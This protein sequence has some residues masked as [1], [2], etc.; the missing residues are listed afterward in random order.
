MSATFN[1]VPTGP[2][3]FREPHG[4]YSSARSETSTVS[5]STVRTGVQ[6]ML[7]VRRRGGGA[8]DGGDNE[9][10]PVRGGGG[11]G[12][13]PYAKQRA[14]KLKSKQLRRQLLELLRA[15]GTAA[16]LC[17]ALRLPPPT[18]HNLEEWIRA[19]VLSPS[20]LNATQQLTDRIARAVQQH[21]DAKELRVAGSTARLTVN[22]DKIDVDLAFYCPNA[23]AIKSLQQLLGKELAADVAWHRQQP[24]NHVR[25]SDGALSHR[26]FAHIVHKSCPHLPA[27]VALFTNKA[28]F[29]AQ[30]EVLNDLRSRQHVY[31]LSRNLAVAMK[32]VLRGFGAFANKELGMQAH[33][34]GMM[35]ELAAL[36][37]AQ[38]YND[39][40]DVTPAML[41][42][43]MR[44]FEKPPQT[45]TQTYK[46]PA[47]D[48]KLDAQPV[49]DLR[50]LAGQLAH[51]YETA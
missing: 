3:S 21:C 10:E 37:V 36:S 22:N 34:P 41:A 11:G 45:L 44:A 51:A 35:I 25:P 13:T 7:P 28:D 42:R 12:Y 1:N 39:V 4:P 15:L 16:A 19:S 14:R 43:G 8:D 46:H 33:A 48:F 29:D 17:Q 5:V 50:F 2:T 47:F 32:G 31:P 20:Q 38:R 27:D 9:F 26:I 49:K 23:A 18:A 24:S 40:R 6:G 30:G